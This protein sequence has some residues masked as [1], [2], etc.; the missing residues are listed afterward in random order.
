MTKETRTTTITYEPSLKQYVKNGVQVESP[1]SDLRVFNVLGNKE[2]I[3]DFTF[4]VI[5]EP[6]QQIQ[7]DGTTK[8]LSTTQQAENRKQLDY[9]KNYEFPREIEFVPATIDTFGR[10]GKKL[11]KWTKD[12]VKLIQGSAMT[13]EY[14]ESINKLRNRIAQQHAIQIGKQVKRTL[15]DLQRYESDEIIA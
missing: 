8:I 7:D 5:K 1:R 11:K 9:D 6:I 14:N 2:S 3:V 15:I 10:W 4:V 13:R 12:I